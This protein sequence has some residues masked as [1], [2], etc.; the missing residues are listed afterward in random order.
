[1]PTLQHLRSRLSSYLLTNAADAAVKRLPS[2]LPRALPPAPV[3]QC[4]LLPHAS[5]LSFSPL[6]GPLAPLHARLAPMTRGTPLSVASAGLGGGSPLSAH[7]SAQVGGSSQFA[8]TQTAQPTL[9]P[10]KPMS[11]FSL[12]KVPV[13][14]PQTSAT[15]QALPTP[16]LQWRHS[17]SH[18]VA[19]AAVCVHSA[20]PGA[21]TPCL[22]H[23]PHPRCWY[24]Q[25]ES[26]K[27]LQ[28][29]VFT[30]LD[31]AGSINVSAWLIARVI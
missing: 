12:P 30:R 26:N 5:S 17:P 19:L 14:V 23:H 20:C 18:N 2:T 1:L 29:V 3:T 9:P 24:V 13:A 16:T 4:C 6:A 28:C 11:T 10:R 21:G 8:S 22:A 31:S 7:C 15:T 25:I 27:A